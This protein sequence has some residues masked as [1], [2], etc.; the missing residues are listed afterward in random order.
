MTNHIWTNKKSVFHFLLK[1]F[2]HFEVQNVWF[3][4]CA[5]HSVIKF[6]LKWT[7]WSLMW[8]CEWIP[9]QGSVC[10]PVCVWYLLSWKVKQWVNLVKIV[11]IAKI[12]KTVKIVK[13][14]K[15]VW[16]NIWTSEPK[17]K[18][19]F[20]KEVAFIKSFCGLPDYLLS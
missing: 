13:I 4:V 8:K 7:F 16:Y 17:V 1:F 15:I 19:L 14:V 6:K 3:Y 12:V 11:K 20:N 2:L 5:Q 10:I 18:L 9:V